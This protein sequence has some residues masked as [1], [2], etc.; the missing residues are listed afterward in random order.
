MFSPS[1]DELMMGHWRMPCTTAR[2][3]NGVKVSLLPVA[4]SKFVFIFSRNFTMRVTS[5]SKTPCT[6]ALVRFDSTM[7][8]AIFLRMTD[9][10]TTSPGVTPP[11]GCRGAT[12]AGIEGAAAE[13]AATAAGC[14]ALR[15]S[16]FDTCDCRASATWRRR[17]SRRGCAHVGHA[18]ENCRAHGAVEAHQRAR[19]RRLRS[20]RDPHREIAREDEDELRA[21]HR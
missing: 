21:G 1:T 20:G 7:C 4:C 11:T 15:C 5:T 3:K 6:C 9:M 8:S 12:V 13:G 14:R 19:A 2:A 18:Q 10:G 17:Y 16:T